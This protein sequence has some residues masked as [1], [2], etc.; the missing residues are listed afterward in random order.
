LGTEDQT[1]ACEALAAKYRSTRKRLLIRE[2]TC[3]ENPTQRKLRHYL[4]CPGEGCVKVYQ[5]QKAFLTHLVSVHNLSQGLLFNMFISYISESWLLPVSMKLNKDILV[6]KVTQVHKIIS[7]YYKMVC[8]FFIS[9]LILLESLDDTEPIGANIIADEIGHIE[10]HIEGHI[11]AQELQMELSQLPQFQSNKYALIMWDLETTGNSF[12]QI[13]QIGAWEMFTN[14]VF[15]RLVKP[16]KLYELFEVI[17]A[18]VSINF[19][20]GSLLHGFYDRDVAD[21][22]GWKEVGAKFFDWVKGFEGLLILF[23]LS[24]TDKQIVFVSHGECDPRWLKAECMR[25]GLSVPE[26]WVFANSIDLA[27]KLLGKQ[28]MVSLE[29]LAGRYQILRYMKF[30]I[31]VDIFRTNT[32]QALPDIHYTWKFIKKMVEE[33]STLDPFTVLFNFAVNGEAPMVNLETSIVPERARTAVRRPYTCS[34]CGRP[35]KGHICLG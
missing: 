15:E 22:P 12:Q 1:S 28:A 17:Y 32:H 16:G 6:C 33:V 9:T 20:Y 4:F 23:S 2:A 30:I 26:N 27:H 10:D 19:Q 25:V 34:K 29:S 8:Q 14:S 18:A 35:K 31:I 13:V 3:K 24:H 11:E 7:V 21:K 5:Y